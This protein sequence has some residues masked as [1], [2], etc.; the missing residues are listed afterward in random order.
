MQRKSVIGS[1][2]F[3]LPSIIFFFYC[4][5]RFLCFFLDGTTS[6]AVVFANGAFFKVTALPIGPSRLK[7]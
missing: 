1:T 2:F 4:P 3:P 6:G 5:K 7:Q